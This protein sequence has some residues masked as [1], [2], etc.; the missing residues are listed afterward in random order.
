MG[1]PIVLRW[2]ESEDR[3]R[4]AAAL[5]EALNTYLT[6]AQ[7]EEEK[8]SHIEES[9]KAKVVSIHLHISCSR[10]TLTYL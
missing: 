7:G 4:A 9:E 5:R 6:A 3:P 10:A 8:Y 2:K 1:D